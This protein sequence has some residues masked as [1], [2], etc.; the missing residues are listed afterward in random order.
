M[1]DKEQILDNTDTYFSLLTNKNRN[2]LISYYKFTT[3]KNITNI[4]RA[5][6]IRKE[7][8][9]KIAILNEKINIANSYFDY[10]NFVINLGWYFIISLLLSAIFVGIIIYVVIQNTSNINDITELLNIS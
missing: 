1:A 2:Q 9:N 10:E 5:E 7:V 4:E 3:I 6:N 8:N